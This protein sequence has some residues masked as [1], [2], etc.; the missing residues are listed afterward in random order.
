[1]T[2]REAIPRRRSMC[3]RFEIHAALEIIG[4][5]FAIAPADVSINYRPSYN[6]A[7]TN[8]VPVILQNGKRRLV[9]CR[10]GFIPSWSREEKTA[11]ALINARAETVAEKPAFSQAFRRQRCI[12]IADGFYE[13]RKSGKTRTPQ[14]IHLKSMQPMGLAGLYNFWTSPEGERICTCTIIVTDAN[15]LIAPIHDRMPVILNPDEYDRWLDPGLQEAEALQPL[16]K[17]Y[18]SEELELHEVSSKVNS[19]KNNSPDL[20]LPIQPT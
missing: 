6:A 3:G 11:F 7:P 13:W 19:P 1:M 15:E 16:L 14:H 9:L 17:P 5:I 18:P 12:V 2:S 8:D 4:R 20:I 10:W